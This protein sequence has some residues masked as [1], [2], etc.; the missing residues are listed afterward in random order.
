MICRMGTLHQLRTTQ[1]EPTPVALHDR[2]MDNLRFIRETMERASAF[3]AVPGWGEVAIGITALGATYIGAQQ[4]T[5]KAWLLTWLLEAL[6]SLII[7]GWFMVRKSKV[8]DMPLLSGP[9]RKFALSFTPPLFAGVILTII[10]YRAGL[11]DSLP[12]TWLLLYGTA[13]V[14]GGTFSV[15]VVPV[16]GFCFMFLGAIS[17]LFSANYGHIFMATGFGLL[18]IIFGTVIARRYGG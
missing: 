6:L 4:R 17:F 18:H 12:G 13:V 7:A 11:S 8:V 9:G 16:M 14:T 5:H 2:A 1:E 15:K 3:T 10:L